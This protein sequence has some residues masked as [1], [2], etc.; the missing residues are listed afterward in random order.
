MLSRI[1]IVIL[2]IVLFLS[3]SSASSQEPPW[4]G[5]VVVVGENR[6]QVNSIDILHRPYRPLHF[7]G[8]ARRR[9][10]YR[11]S[12]LPVPRDWVKGFSALATTR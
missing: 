7:Y 1:F 11:G 4:L 2:T 6:A 5:R 12:M 3:A 10:Y 9:A 8:N